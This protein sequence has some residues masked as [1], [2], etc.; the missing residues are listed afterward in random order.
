MRYILAAV[1]I[2]A[3]AGYVVSV[4]RRLTKIGADQMEPGYLY[5]E[6]Y[7]AGT[8]P[9]KRIVNTRRL[10]GESVDDWKARHAVRVADSLAEFPPV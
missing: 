10:E 5:H 9:V 2:L 1:L 3:C 6:H 4:E 7:S 8:P